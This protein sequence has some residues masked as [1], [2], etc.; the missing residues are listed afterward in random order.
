MLGQQRAVEA[1]AEGCRDTLTAGTKGLAR[2]LGLMVSQLSI[3][4]DL[5]QA[6]V[7]AVI[8]G[9]ALLNGSIDFAAAQA[10]ARGSSMEVHRA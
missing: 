4:A 5:A 9:E 2:E 10:L 3:V 7:S 1:L 6:G 8:L